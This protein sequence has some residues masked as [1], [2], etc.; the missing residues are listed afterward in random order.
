MELLGSLFYDRIIIGASFAGTMVFDQLSLVARQNTLV[1]N[2]VSQTSTWLK[3]GAERLMTQPEEL[4]SPGFFESSSFV[5][6]EVNEANI[7]PY[8]YTRMHHLAYAQIEKQN[9][10]NMPIVNLRA[11]I[12]EA[13]DNFDE[14]IKWEDDNYQYRILLSHQGFIKYVYTQH[15]D[16]CLGLG[17][18]KHL[19]SD[20]I[21]PE[22]EIKALKNGTLIYDPQDSTQLRDGVIFYGASAG[23]GTMLAEIQQQKQHGLHSNLQINGWYTRSKGDFDDGKMLT[24]LNRML[25]A[26]IISER[27]KQDGFSL[28]YDGYT[29]KKVELADENNLIALFQCTGSDKEIRVA[30]PQLVVAI[31]Q[32]P[33]D[34]VSRIV[35]SIKFIP[36]IQ[37]NIPLGIIAEDGR[38]IVWGAAASTKSSLTCYLQNAHEADRI[39]ELITAHANTLPYESKVQPGIFNIY[40]KI[41]KL[42]QFTSQEYDFPL[43]NPTSRE[44]YFRQINAASRNELVEIFKSSPENGKSY[45]ADELFVFA[46]VIIFERSK[47]QD[48]RIR[49][50]GGIHSAD[51]LYSLQNTI[52]LDLLN[53][54][55]AH[56]FPH[57]AKFKA[58]KEDKTI[59]KGLMTYGL[60]AVGTLV[61]LGVAVMYTKSYYKS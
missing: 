44:K 5:L 20:Q 37:H 14:K 60:F 18:E 30:C 12:I 54:L 57:A 38:I 53:R 1:L 13:R 46:D 36:I 42:A 43:R 40:K 25:T 22:V 4:Q 33:I 31:S 29:L 47:V 7:N 16:L 24:T 17:S 8:Y 19:T 9:A 27:Q 28:L 58:C 49:K 45:S 11:G 41:E 59:R 32:E 3:G 2:D 55:R 15:I 10:L 39:F 6:D 26:T 23:C 56:Y 50:P 48:Y 34:L 52:P 21:A 35:N 61:S 51:H